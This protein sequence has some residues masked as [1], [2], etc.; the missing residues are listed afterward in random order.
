[1]T[2]PKIAQMVNSPKM[3]SVVHC[4]VWKVALCLRG[5]PL[6]RKCVL[7]AHQ[8]RHEPQAPR[9]VL[10]VADQLIIRSELRA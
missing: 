7:R 8:D 2:W 1:M 4:A 9:S 10:S 3:R 5:R 6:D